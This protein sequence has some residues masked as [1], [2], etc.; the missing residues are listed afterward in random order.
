M[1]R[2]FP[3]CLYYVALNGI[4]R[5][6][7]G[8]LYIIGPFESFPLFREKR[9]KIECYLS[10]PIYLWHH[11]SQTLSV[12]CDLTKRL[13][14]DDHHPIF[15]YCNVCLYSS[16]ICLIGCKANGAKERIF[17]K[18]FWNFDKILLAEI[19]MVLAKS[20]FTKSCRELLHISVTKKLPSWIWCYFNGLIWLMLY[21]QSKTDAHQ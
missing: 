13:W 18:R 21:Q 1:N 4:H 20:Q 10:K 6:C 19:M 15:D 5:E 16:P 2:R 17:R 3:F 9:L 12:S 14:I 11:L 8:Q 7:R